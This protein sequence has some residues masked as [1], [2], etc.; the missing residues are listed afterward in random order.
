MDEAH[1]RELLET[2]MEIQSQTMK[3]IGREIHDNIGQ[4]LTLASLYAQQLVHE[5]RAPS[6]SKEVHEIGEIINHSLDEL[7][8]LSK[9]LTSDTVENNSL[10]DLLEQECGRVNNLKECKVSFVNNAD[11]KVNSY[12]IKSILFRIAQEFLQ[13]SIKHSKCKHIYVSLSKS[14]GKLLL[15]LR[16]DGKG[17]DIENLK[18]K[19][20]G[21][22]NIERRTQLLGG[23]LY[24]KSLT[25]KGTKL[26]V[27]IPV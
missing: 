11:V 5:K 18:T 23:S 25:N 3:H 4:K 19:G 22:R 1:K 10:V 7:R 6:I 27:E 12:P 17:F 26:K 8:Q 13:N 15:E 9:S 21:L 16:D 24:L 20:I 2:Q 14:A